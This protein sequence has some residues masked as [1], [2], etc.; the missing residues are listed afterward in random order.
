MFQIQTFS[1]LYG[2]QMSS[3]TEAVFH[4]NILMNKVN[5]IES[6]LPGV[7]LFKYPVSEI[8]SLALAA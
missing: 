7:F 1:Q 3:I 5:Y 4:W 2:L 8:F 6:H